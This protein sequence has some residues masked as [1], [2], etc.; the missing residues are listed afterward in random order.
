MA[1]DGKEFTLL[2]PSKNTAYKGPNTPSKNPSGGLENMRPSLFF[3]AMVIRGIASDDE[4]TKS[5]DSDTVMDATI[6]SFGD[7]GRAVHALAETVRTPID[8]HLYSDMQRTAMPA[9]FADLVLPANVT[10]T[11]HPVASG[12]QRRIG[13]LKAST[14]RPTCLIPRIRIVPAFA[15]WS[16]DL[17]LP[18][19]PKP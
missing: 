13:R 5:A 11:L 1:S 10:L 14:H 17:A 4:Y 7:L 18:R 19:P 9:N 2:I 16:P 6:A 8:V 3:D 15:P 12:L